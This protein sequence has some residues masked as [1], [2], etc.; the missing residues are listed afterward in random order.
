MKQ[1][2]SDLRRY[3]FGIFGVLSL[4]GILVLGLVLFHERVA[5]FN[6]AGEIARQ[7]RDLFLFAV[8]LILIVVIPVF[9]MLFWFAWKFR[10]NN[11]KASYRP[12]FT[13]SKKLET[14][15]WGIPIAIIIVL[16]S[17]TWVTSHTLDPFRPL[18][19]NKVPLQVQVIALQWK[20]LFIY[21]D[22]SVASVNELH[23]PS[24]RPVEFTITSDAPM[25]S[26]W[27]P[28]L[29]GQVYAMSG[30]STKLHLIADKKGV[31]EGRSANISGKGF[32]DMEFATIV[33]SQ[34][35]F[36]AWQSNLSKQDLPALNTESYSKLAHKSVE[37]SP[38]FYVRADKDLYNAVIQ[39][40][41]EHNQLTRTRGQR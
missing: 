14:L 30:M 15:W 12:E 3:L 4:A 19:S 20:W 8:A 17:V 26:F 21:L 40:Y 28:K 32:A 27:I 31:Y 18:A 35:E 13:G 36:N 33:T 16:A 7:Q 6:P 37:K 38:R 34:S 9:V 23:L 24:D 11:K 5:F 2:Q 10:E 22:S 39:S 29:G 41:M 1:R 25:N